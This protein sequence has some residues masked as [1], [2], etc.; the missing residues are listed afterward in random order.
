MS[1]FR[2]TLLGFWR[3]A[4]A[5]NT[6]LLSPDPSLRLKSGSVR[7]DAVWAALPSSLTAVVD[8]L[9]RSPYHAAESFLTLIHKEI[10]GYHAPCAVAGSF[11][12]GSG[13]GCLVVFIRLRY[14]TNRN[15]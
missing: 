9:D 13:D 2:I 3:P 11:H 14:K 12:R 1:A 4:L 6:A 7:D 15:R 5:P 10:H 8:L